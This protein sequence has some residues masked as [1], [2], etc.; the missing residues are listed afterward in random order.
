MTLLLL[1]QT[2][3]VQTFVAEKV[4][5]KLSE[6]IDGNISIEKIHF[7]PFSHLVVKNIVIT[8]K[9]PD[10]DP[11]NPSCE[12]IDTLFKAKY[13]MADFALTSL[14]GDEGIGIDKVIVED[15]QLNLVIEHHRTNEGMSNNLTRMFRLDEIK[16]QKIDKE[17]FHIDDV[18]ID[19][20]TFILKNYSSRKTSFRGGIN[21]NDLEVRNIYATAEDLR[22]KSGVMTGKA[23][24][25]SFT[26]K[27]GYICNSMTGSARVGNGLTHIT[28][29]R[30]I[31]PWSEIHMPDGKLIYSGVKDFSDYIHA[32]V[33]DADIG[34]SFIDFKSLSFFAPELEGNQLKVHGYK[35]HFH[36]TVDDFT[37]TDAQ[38]EM[39]GGGFIGTIS[40]RMT[41]IPEVMTTSLEGQVK[42]CRITSNG[43]S[44]FVT[45]WMKGGKLDLSWLAPGEVFTINGE[46]SGTLNNMIVH[47]NIISSL[48]KA[49]GRDVRIDNILSSDAV[50]KI[51]GDIS[52][53]NLDLGKV[54][55]TDLLGP[56]TLSVTADA[57]FGEDDSPVKANISNLVVERL[58]LYGY[59]YTG[60]SG[61]AMISDEF[62]DGRL[63]C[64]DPSLTFMTHGRYGISRTN[65][66][67]KYDFAVLV[68]DADL[69][70]IK[71]D[72]RGKSKTR[73]TMTADF[74]KTPDDN[75]Y[76]TIS[77][78]G[79]MLE[80]SN[81]S[82]NI[83]D[84]TLNSINRSNTY[85]MELT[86]SFAEGNLTGT[87]P[88]MDFV[89]DLMG[90]TLK[91]EVPALFKDPSYT[92]NGNRYKLYFN[93]KDTQD[94]LAWALPGLYIATGTN[95][96]AEIKE[97]GRFNLAMSS[98]RIAYE[99]QYL[100]DVR[101]NLTNSDDALT[102]DITGSE[103]K[104]GTL[105]LRDNNLKM[106]ADDN[107]IGISY[108]YENT[109]KLE[110]R[111][112]FV[113]HGGLA[114][115]V[116]GLELDVKMLPSTLYLNSRE[117]RI[118]D[119]YLTA[120]N[121]GI[122]SSD[123]EL[124]SNEQRI[125]IS[126]GTS[127]TKVDTM[128][129]N[130]EQFD[131]SIINPLFK[132]DL[133]ISG[134]VSGNV[135]L[136]SPMS[137]K[138]IL[139]DIACD[140]AY[141]ADCR[142]GTL[143]ASST[144]DEE[145]KRFNISA[146]TEIDGRKSIEF[147]GK[148]TPKTTEIEAAATLNR[149]PVGYLQPLMN[150]VFSDLH[151]YVSG[152]LTAEGPIDNLRWESRNTILEDG[153]LRV[154]FTNVPY[155]VDGRFRFTSE[156]LFFDEIN[157]HDRYNG[158]AGLTG[159]IT[160]DNRFGNIFYDINI[161]CNEIEGINLNDKQNEY[162]YGNVFGSGNVTFSGPT[163]DMVMNVEGR[164][165]KEGSLHVPISYTSVSG[166]SN[167]LRF[168][169]IKEE[170]PV[171][172][173]DLILKKF[174]SHK[175]T[176]SKFTT[177]MKIEA[178]P[179]VDA[180]I[181]FD[182]TSGHMLSGNG[183]GT[184]QMYVDEDV[185]DITGDYNIQRGNYKFVAYGI[186]NR[187]FEIQD[188]SSITFVGDIFDSN[189][190]I[191][192]MYKTKASIG[193]LIGDSTAVSNRRTVECKIKITDK[194]LNPRLQ[195]GIEIPEL[196][197]I[198]KSRV[199]SA[200]STE[201]KVQKQFLSLLISNSFLP[202]E[203]SG[204]V[205]NSTML[206]SNVT[207]VMASQLNNILEKLDI[208][209]D[210][211][212]NYQPNTKG[213]D[214]FD[215]AVSTQM[216]NNRVVVNGSVGNKQYAETAQTDVV[217]DLDIEIKLNKSGAFRLNLFS[218]SADSYTNYLDNS[219]RNGV[220][221]TYQTEFSTFRQFIRNLFSSRKKRQEAKI[222]EEDAKA[223]EER[224]ILKIERQDEEQ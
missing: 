178:Q 217:G 65:Q 88:V 75:I 41:G 163:N 69:N 120:N 173:Y 124:T 32:V 180:Y 116:D 99:S 153:G 183:N 176:D 11:D 20:F 109:G 136:T 223:D 114:R 52:T 161:T 115:N 122:K 211:G 93:F 160:W 24:G 44:R 157:G 17:I 147:T 138:G 25:L 86:S 214:V 187:D 63:T 91:R 142:I 185:F 144:W 204:I 126:G 56:V 172:P 152:N 167:L 209:L 123:V 154:D 70:K 62:I 182:K 67:T 197:P 107:H 95:L 77:V 148:L 132:T 82:Y 79:L 143:N 5:E 118:R 64:D 208:P 215:V 105:M 85:K 133:G 186:V 21:W 222:A 37:V 78:G 57:T 66:D 23:T 96:N 13:I 73:F 165:A 34:T 174:E 194:M 218:H 28:D 141:F 19:N 190:D 170:K 131:I 224:T 55:E 166:R 119:S 137:D 71:L 112:E 40:G 1:A 151:G 60:I 43:L 6:N 196:D 201:D 54:L 140:S 8:D 168:T 76:G 14:I 102:G 121:D 50:M 97:T 220:G 188:G 16:K 108:G 139:V 47:P 92:W 111:G 3:M 36:G 213:K 146:Q 9:A 94:V 191:D 181:W 203:Q 27:S 48:G 221:L 39:E 101:L 110:N 81:G 125:S 45:Y 38:V 31:D 2:P 192:A 198:I 12:I 26:E 58:H 145:F 4:L 171:D 59:D 164:T 212:L 199:E 210:L 53:D 83:G 7:K 158:T 68:G 103:L 18:K 89:K 177:K 113:I 202:D 10:I 35:G 46:V 205:N 150:G 15:G 87:A 135:H 155:Y 206:Y 219:Q 159:G 200:L 179:E 80:N 195:F 104:V 216:F 128:S 33:M 42:D 127:K 117:W 184:I 74:T 90:V 129:L 149:L 98:Q 106:L 156:G 130:L 29:C 207:E 193:T 162:F 30:L 51:S 100:K 175:T 134:S 72:K 84:I 61:E 169:E 22:F 189:L 49:S